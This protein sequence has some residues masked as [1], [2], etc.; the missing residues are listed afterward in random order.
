MRGL[1]GKPLPPEVWEIVAAVLILA[2]R[3]RSLAPS[4]LWTDWVSILSVF[5]IFIAAAGKT[6][7]ASLVTAAVM[8][9]LLLLYASQQMPLTLRVL[10]ATP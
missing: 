4:T 1:S 8:S 9:A 6:R 3:V 2:W 7:A 5:W 10:G